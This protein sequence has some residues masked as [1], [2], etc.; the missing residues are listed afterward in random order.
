MDI[1]NDPDF[2]AWA[3]EVKENLVPKLEQSPITISI[4]PRGP[5]DIKYAVELGLSI[6]MDKPIILA[7]MPGT[8]IPDKLRRVADEIVELPLPGQSVVSREETRIGAER[9][10]EAMDRVI[11]RYNLG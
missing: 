5:G 1:E 6:L 11:K 3:K 9:M 4:A 2:K 8:T 7:V 10:R